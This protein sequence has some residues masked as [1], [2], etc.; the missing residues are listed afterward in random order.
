M[1]KKT[2]PFFWLLVLFLVHLILLILTTFTLWPEMLVY[3]YLLNHGFALYS[4]IINPYPPLL[5]YLLAFFT[6]Q[7]SYNVLSIQILTYASILIIDTSIF[8]LSLK[9][10]KKPHLALTSLAFFVFFSVPFGVNGIWF[11]LF[12]T[13][14]ILFSTYF[15]YKFL[16]E[17]K[18]KKS[19]LISFFFLALA[20]SIKQ[21]ALWLVGWFI[22]VLFLRLKN[23]KKNKSLFLLYTAAVFLITV[24]FL[25][26]TLISQKQIPELIYWAIYVPYLKSSTL[27]GYILLPNLKQCLI[28]FLLVGVFAPSIIRR[29]LPETFLPLTGFILFL[30]AYPRFD[31][32]HLVPALAVLS[33]SFAKNIYVITKPWNKQATVS[34]VALLL[35]TVFSARYFQRNWQTNTRFFEDDVLQTAKFVQ[36]INPK[37]HPVFLQNVSGQILVL[38][39]TLPTKPWADSFPWYLELPGVQQKVLKGLEAEKPLLVIYKPYENKGRYDLASYRPAKIADYLN[40]N[41]KNIFSIS[42][43]LILRS[44]NSR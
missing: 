40:S 30:F 31:Y 29:K 41:Y 27:P 4:D 9:L 25:V 11:D 7:F 5:P 18:N 39:Q 43:G 21:Q 1:L 8:I 38:S 22:A 28:L 32:F 44:L 3:P 37:D 16:Q 20:F 24:S 42:D 36:I 19:L 6:K 15:F 34:I 13:I 33:I 23:T 12:Q 26:L 35:L 14:P 2:L 17:I 10:T